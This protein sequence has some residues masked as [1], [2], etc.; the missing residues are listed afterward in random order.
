MGV[1]LPLADQAEA[2]VVDILDRVLD[3]D[4]VALPLPV[5]EVDHRGEGGGLARTGGARDQHQAA[6]VAGQRLEDGGHAKFVEGANAAADGP[7]DGTHASQVAEYVDPETQLLGGHVGEVGVA[8]PLEGVAHPL[9]H[10]L[11]EQFEG[12]VGA[13]AAILDRCDLTVDA[14]PRWVA[15]D[16]MELG[17]LLFDHQFQKGIDPVHWPPPRLIWG[18][19]EGSVTKR[20][21]RCLSVAWM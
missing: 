4:D 13:Q 3:G 6:V 10:D 5:D 12:L 21:K 11:V 7:E 18:R 20:W 17:G 9:R 1:D 15:G 8:V 14:D 2:V 16:Q 19:M